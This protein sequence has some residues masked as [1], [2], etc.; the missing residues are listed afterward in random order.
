MVHLAGWSV[1][2]KAEA[3]AI[4]A[5]KILHSPPGIDRQTESFSLRARITFCYITEHA[6]VLQR[7][8]SVPAFCFNDKNFS[9]IS[10][11]H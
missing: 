5:Q 2:I 4:F 11:L 9:E 6:V 1:S 8:K 10:A 3:K 7:D